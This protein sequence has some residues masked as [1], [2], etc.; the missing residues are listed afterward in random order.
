MRETNLGIKETKKDKTKTLV[1][2]DAQLQY[3]ANYKR[4]NKLLS[5]RKLPALRA[6]PLPLPA[7]DP[8]PSIS[9]LE[10]IQ[11]LNLLPCCMGLVKPS[12]SPNILS[13]KGQKFGDHYL[14]A[15]ST[16]LR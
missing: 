16:A 6:K 3:Y 13:V 10:Q 9:V 8:D 14:K 1:G 4:L 12:G 7:L 11:A 2:K 5:L 15:V